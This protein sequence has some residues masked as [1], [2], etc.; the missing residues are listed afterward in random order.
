M[1]KDQGATKVGQEGSPKQCPKVEGKYIR[2]TLS[3]ESGSTFEEW[4]GLAHSLRSCILPGP[5]RR[6]IWS[7]DNTTK[8]MD[9]R[10]MG[11]YI[12][13][14]SNLVVQEC[15]ALGYWEHGHSVRG[16]LPR[17]PAQ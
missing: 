1:D 7:L 5:H 14:A 6:Q 3:R 8:Y 13:E 17:Y 9:R 11:Q 16:A 10:P 2:E 4:T 12:Y 15:T